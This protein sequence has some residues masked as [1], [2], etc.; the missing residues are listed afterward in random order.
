[1]TKKIQL[2]L[3]CVMTLNF[4]FGKA[5][6][7]QIISL[8]VPFESLA[9]FVNC[10]GTCDAAPAWGSTVPP[11]VGV[12]FIGFH[13]FNDPE[14][15]SGQ[16]STPLIPGNSYTYKV[17]ATIA[18][19]TAWGAG[20]GNNDGVIYLWA[21]NGSCSQNQLIDSIQ[22]F[23]PID[24]NNWKQ[25]CFTFTANG[26]Y[27]YLS[28]YA[29][30]EAQDY[31]NCAYMGIDDVNNNAVTVTVTTVPCTGTG[32]TAT[33]T[34]NGGTPPYT[35][36]WS[37]SG[38]TNATATGLSAGTYTVTITD[39]NTSTCNPPYTQTIV[40]PASSSVTALFSA[41]TACAGNST[42]FTDNSTGG[43]IQWN[44]NFGDGDTSVLQNPSHIYTTSGAHTVTLVVSNQ[45]GAD[46]LTQSVIS[47]SPPLV[48]TGLNDSICFGA[49]AA[50]SLTPNGTG[51]TYTWS[52][53]SGLSN[54]AIF[55]PLAAPV[56]ATTYT[57][58]VTDQN[59]C[60]N[61]DS[62]TIYVDPEINIVKTVINAT[63]NGI[64]DGQTTVI[65]N[66]G[67]A[68]YTY[69]WTG[70]S[71]N[72]S[73][74]NL[75]PNSYTVTVTDAFGCS[76][77]ADTIV[78][79]TLNSP[80]SVIANGSAS[81]CIGASVPL[82]ALG[83]GGNGSS[84]TYTWTPATGLNLTTGTN[85][86][87]TPGVTT[88]YTVTATITNSCG[89]AT[90]SDTVT[91]IVLPLP[92]PAFSV[93]VNQGCAPLCVHFTNSS[94]VSVGSIIDWNWNFGDGGIISGTQ[95][96]SHC[97]NSPGQYSITLTV[98]SNNGCI[99]TSTINNMI[100][101]FANPVAA[102]NPSPNPT[103]VF[104]PNVMMNNQSSF[105]VN[106]W[107]WSFGDGD[108]LAPSVSNPIH[109]YPNAALGSYLATLIVHNADG[110]YDTVAHQIFI[111]TEFAFFIPNSFS[112]NEDHVNDFFFGSGVGITKYDLW[113]FDRWGDMIFHGK[114]LNDKWNGKANKGSE[115]VQQD[116]Y[117]WKVELTDVFGKL[118]HYIGTVTLVE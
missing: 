57:V 23:T 16:L 111:G 87:A 27:D 79:V 64:C 37:P 118:H 92:V 90:A 53:A 77:T 95:N 19:I 20:G 56:V 18:P 89:T 51:Y 4:I 21:G 25:F 97:F 12:G 39:G 86:T 83:A 30:K 35:Y 44:W 108:T 93:D 81:I 48:N 106:Y 71:T 47:S 41:S 7:Q 36:S 72:A 5:N 109:S 80:L 105:D 14:V 17:M 11:N 96:P 115:I 34:V 112:P 100:K 98:T 29:K 32:A 84:I 63:C 74:T 67:T 116:V 66:G 24:V 110:C 33:A 104:D 50:L 52:P 107:H 68:P 85:V 75:C 43:A 38:G 60:F 73:C 26:N 1:M 28:F 31:V 59:G 76:L 55:N 10:A 69:S 117:V 8:N 40:I 58:I 6:A 2:I 22:L 70:G 62:I 78:T 94:T 54:P 49:S 103:D 102:F 46:T 88:N 82:T 91:V 113:I 9:G 45:C 13:E 61:S 15:F 42:V 65:P 101:V 114:D 99:A 3:F